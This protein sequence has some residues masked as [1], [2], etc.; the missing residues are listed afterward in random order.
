MIALAANS[1]YWQEP[2][3]KDPLIYNA[4]AM[5][6]SLGNGLVRDGKIT[7][8][9]PP[10]YPLFLGGIYWIFGM[11][12]LVILVFQA[13]LG[14]LTAVFIYRLGE[15]LYGRGRSAAWICGLVCVF[16]WPLIAIG[17]KILTETLF[18]LFLVSS[19]YYTLSALKEKRLGL[20]VPGA[21]L[22]GLATLTRS[23]TFYLPAIVIAWLA[24]RWLKGKEKIY[25]SG[26]VLYAVVF[27]FSQTPWIVRNYM[28]L[29]A[30]IPTT[31]NTG[32]VLYMSNLPR[33]GKIFGWNLRPHDLEPGQRYILAL[34][35]VERDRALKKL[36]MDWWK[37]HPESIPRLTAYKFLYFWSPFD[38]EVMGRSEGVFNPWFVWVFLFALYGVFYAERK[39]ELLPPLA[40]V[41]YFMAICTLSYGSP[42]LRLPAEPFLAIVAA[43]G[44]VAMEGRVKSGVKRNLVLLIVVITAAAGCLYSEWI[45]ETC[46]KVLT[47]A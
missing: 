37:D 1:S 44:W 42:R 30:F 22:L 47:W 18:I 35:E 25:L 28:Q 16:Y 38:W 3:N 46:R 13:L 36:A 11:N 21:L 26:I 9:I 23:I 8:S 41:L 10:L 43:G 20:L 27:I 31:T 6:V 17:M 29:S 32:Q 24:W 40:V 14:A 19:A 34:P 4:M 39:G 5:D 2:L 12:G 15:L 7:A 33:E 45:K